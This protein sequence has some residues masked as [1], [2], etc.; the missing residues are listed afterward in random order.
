MSFK[1]YHLVSKAQLYFPLSDP[2]TQDHQSDRLQ[3]RRELVLWQGYGVGTR[4]EGADSPLR[5]VHRQQ[6]K[7]LLIFPLSFLFTGIVLH[8]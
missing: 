2:H 6:R 1:S 4:V 3:R 7:S 8:P 5:A